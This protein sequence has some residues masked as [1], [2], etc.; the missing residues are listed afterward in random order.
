MIIYRMGIIPELTVAV[1]GVG[2]PLLYLLGPATWLG[3]ALTGGFGRTFRA[4]PAV[5]WTAFFAC[6][7]LSALFSSWIGGSADRLV[8]YIKSE[9]V[10]LFALAG[11]ITLWSEIRKT[12]TG[13]AFAGAVVLLAAR[14]WATPGGDGRLTFNLGSDGT[15]TNPNDLAAHIILLTPFLIYMVMKPD[16][17]KLVKL[18]SAVLIGYGLWII[19]GT[20]S[21][22]GMIGVFVMFAIFF[23]RATGGQRVVA[24]VMV[25][26][27]L[28]GLVAA[29]P[30]AALVRLG[31]MFGSG[32]ATQSGEA[33]ESME[34][35]SYLVKKSIEYTLEHPLLGVGPNQFS[36][37]EGMAMKA[38]GQ[39]GNWHETHNT[40][41]QLSSECGIP[42]CILVISA[43]LLTLGMVN[44]T[45]SKATAAG[46]RDMQ[47]MCTCF[48][49]SFAAYAVTIT[50]LACAYRFTLPAMVGLGIAIHYAGDREIATRMAA[51][52]S[53]QT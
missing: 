27:L 25:P 30:G 15:I 34:S 51:A 45:H 29:A 5:L 2:I 14:I 40:Y 18:I 4:T 21:R 12:F 36:N 49:A 32:I 26:L 33:E 13:L 28:G 39:Q 6:M 46:C 24:M 44:R 35:R 50:F 47:V 20:A 37:Y 53:A 41:T 3:V 8:A 11:T 48:L 16:T 9:Y 10:C 17:A 22:G 7:I 42:A 1:L 19:L 23:V 43:M 31:T 52:Q 38:L